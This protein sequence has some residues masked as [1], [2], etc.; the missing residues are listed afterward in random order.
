MAKVIKDH[1]W[2]GAWGIVRLY[3]WEQ[4]FDGRVWQLERGKDFR[5][6]VRSMVTCAHSAARKLG[7]KVRC[8]TGPAGVGD[9]DKTVVV[10]QAFAAEDGENGQEVQEDA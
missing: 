3:P 6:S 8:N 1:V 10:L 5:V 2:R 4:W 9:N 7:I